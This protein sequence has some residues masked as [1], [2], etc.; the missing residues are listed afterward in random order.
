MIASPC[1]TEL[2]NNLA[3]GEGGWRNRRHGKEMPILDLAGLARS[4]QAATSVLQGASLDERDVKFTEG[5]FQAVQAEIWRD[6]R[7]VAGVAITSE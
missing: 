6:A 3:D 2:R 7:A 5:K 4:A 1:G